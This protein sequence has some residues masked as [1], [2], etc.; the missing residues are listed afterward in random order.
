MRKII[1][2][3]G[4]VAAHARRLK[5]LPGKDIV[6]YGFGEIAH[7]LLGNGL[8]DEARL[9]LHPFFVR[10]AEPADLLFR[11]GSLAR[12]DLAEATPLS[13]GIVVL[14]YRNPA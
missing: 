7:T 11:T 1:N 2:S 8:L 6:H 10:D 14:T 5:A 4:A 9:W 12:F 13:S 3:S